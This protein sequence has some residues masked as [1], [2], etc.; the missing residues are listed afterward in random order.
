MRN[1]ALVANSTIS[2]DNLNISAT[3]VDL[4]EKVVYA[5]SEKPNPDGEVDIELWRTG[6][7]E[8]LGLKGASL[9]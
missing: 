2:L 7:I 9:C 1:L 8:G 6:K 5:V 3:T 4:D